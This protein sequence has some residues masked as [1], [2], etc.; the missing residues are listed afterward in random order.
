[1]MVLAGIAWGAYSLLGRVSPGDPVTM[2]ASS[3][4]RALPMAAGLFAASAPMFGV[5]ASPRGIVLAA[6]SGA[7]ASGVGYSV[8]YAALRHL[9]MT[10]AAVLQLLVPV[11]SA[12]GAVALLGE[13]VSARLVGASA[14]ILGGVA[15]TIR[16]RAK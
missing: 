2:T 16:A 11:L 3:F 10:R 6:T 14:A 7:L 12:A 9:S 1:I 15:L 13:H 5:H 4:S 8:W